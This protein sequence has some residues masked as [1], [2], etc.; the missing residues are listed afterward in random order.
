VAAFTKRLSRLPIAKLLRIELILAS[1][2]S[3][4]GLRGTGLIA[5]NPPWT[6]QDELQ[7]LLPVLSGILSRGAKSRLT[8]GWLTGESAS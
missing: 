2:G 7:T 5:V 4:L 1:T 6:L 8:L 3:D